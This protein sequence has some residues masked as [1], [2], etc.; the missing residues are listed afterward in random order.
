MTRKAVPAESYGGRL[1]AAMRAAG[2]TNAALAAAVG[3][4]PATVSQWRTNVFLPDERRNA[5]IAAAVRTS[6]AWLRYGV[7]GGG[8]ERAEGASPAAPA[9]ATYPRH[10]EGMVKRFEADLDEAPISDALRASL[11][12]VL[13]DPAHAELYTARYEAGQQTVAEQRVRM[14]AH[15]ARLR[16]LLAGLVTDRQEVGPTPIPFEDEGVPYRPTSDAARQGTRA[17]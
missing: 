8:A 1:M 6:P 16:H 3:V 2:L 15:V 11:L 12:G 9:L 5:L 7:E 4:D 17:S 14:E 13:R 10:V